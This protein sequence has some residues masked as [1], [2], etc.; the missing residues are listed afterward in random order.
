MSQNPRSQ[1]APSKLNAQWHNAH[2]MPPKASLEQRIAW[3]LEHRQ[4]CSCLPIPA[5][6]QAEIAK[7]AVEAG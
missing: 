5:R 6:L 3:H 1:F 7:R 4:N 2:P